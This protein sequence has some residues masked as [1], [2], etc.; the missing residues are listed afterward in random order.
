MLL[1]QDTQEKRLR[2]E[3]AYYANSHKAD[4]IARRQLFR[5]NGITY[6]EMLENLCVLLDDEISP[7]TS[8][9][10]I[11]QQTKMPFRF[12]KMLFLLLR[13]PKK[14]STSQTKCLLSCGKIVIKNTSGTWPIWNESKMMA[15]S[16]WIIWKEPS[17]LLIQS[18]NIPLKRTFN[19]SKK[20]KYSKSKL[21]V[22]GTLLLTAE[23]VFLTFPML[24]TYVANLTNSLQNRPNLSFYLIFLLF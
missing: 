5:I 24:K 3:M 4:K 22:N 14:N 2:T 12:L 6:E 13:N 8:T 16:S 10:P 20:T 1:G 7:E 15:P 23:S 17:L 19:M 9:L 21:M 18:G 11:Y